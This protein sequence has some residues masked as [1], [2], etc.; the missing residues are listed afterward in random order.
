MFEV[1]SVSLTEMEGQSV[2][3]VSRGADQA[4]IWVYA[5]A[6][7]FWIY[8]WYWNEPRKVTETRRNVASV[9]LRYTLEY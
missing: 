4:H 8:F 1:C 7:A 5:K 9:R 3:E 6:S 2:H